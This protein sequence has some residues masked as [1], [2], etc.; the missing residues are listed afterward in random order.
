MPLIAPV[1]DDRTFEQIYTELR[2]RIPVYNH[3]W[4]DFNESDPAITLLQ[5]FAYLGEGLQFRFNQIPEATQLA[6]LK[7]L[8]LP[9][10]PATPARALVRCTTS[11]PEG[12][13]IYAGDQLKA[14]K[15][16]FTIEN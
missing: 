5:L 3:E 16:L 12:A 2:E 6:F 4:T 1:L 11:H 7:M 13:A 15:T 9:L 14:G 8:G 10:T